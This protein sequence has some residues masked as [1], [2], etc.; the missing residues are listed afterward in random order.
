V[1]LAPRIAVIKTIFVPVASFDKHDP[2]I[3][4][5]DRIEFAALL[6]FDLTLFLV[7]CEG[8]AQ[9]VGD[10]VLADRIGVIERSEDLVAEP[11]GDLTARCRAV[12]RGGCY[13]VVAFG[14]GV[15]LKHYSKTILG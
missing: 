6:E 13:G 9:L 3:G 1:S 12:D 10:F 5:A 11:P 8:V 4:L 15:T 14:H 7:V 2:R